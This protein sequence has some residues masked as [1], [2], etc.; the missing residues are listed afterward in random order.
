MYHILFFYFNIYKRISEISHRN[1]RI[2]RNI[3]F[4]GQTKIVSEPN[5][6][7]LSSPLFH[8][9]TPPFSL[10]LIQNMEHQFV[11]KK[12]MASHYHSLREDVC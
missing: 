5:F 6:I 3:S 11:L 10:F 1:L 2:G 8:L 12:V 9:A 7:T 4:G